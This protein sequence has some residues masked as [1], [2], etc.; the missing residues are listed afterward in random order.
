MIGLI[1]LM[2]YMPKYRVCIFGDLEATENSL[3]DLEDEIK[4]NL[5]LELKNIDITFE[6]IK[7]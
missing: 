2:S 3:E 5:S 7:E 1:K 4:F 6:E